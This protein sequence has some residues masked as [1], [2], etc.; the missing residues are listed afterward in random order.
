V[1]SVVNAK[2][3][4]ERLRE[5]FRGA[6]PFPHLVLDDLFAEEPLQRVLDAFPSPDAAVWRR[7]DNERE[8]KLGIREG[9]GWE[10][11]RIASFLLAA[12][13]P[14]MLEFLERLSGIEGLVPD[15]YFAGGGLHQTVRGGFLKVHADFNWHP[16]LRL[17]RRLNMLVYLNR[18]W[19]E[20][21]GGALELWAPGGKR[22]AKSILPVFNRTV[23]FA[24]SDASL[25]GHPRPLDCPADRTRKSISLYYYTNGRPEEERSAPHDT[26]FLEETAP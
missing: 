12:S 2:A 26:Q 1:Q 5:Q 23:I 13:A 15:P 21:Y 20:E 4:P 16:K 9:L 14:P 25:H 18:D 10:D 17:D 24:T 7:F 6:H 8:R 22:A 3:D 19:R 11:E